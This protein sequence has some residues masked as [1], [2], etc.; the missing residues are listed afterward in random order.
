MDAATARGLLIEQF[1][2]VWAGATPL[3]YDNDTREPPPAPAS[4]ARIN[5]R[6]TGAY[7]RTLGSKYEVMAG[8]V[9]VTLYTEAGAGTDPFD[10]LATL[11]RGA[12]RRRFLGSPGDILIT[13][14]SVT[15]ERGLD[16]KGWYQTLIST[17]FEYT[18]TTT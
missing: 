15:E 10:T 18:E 1:E 8:S 5:I 17:R 7:T 9:F 12:L 3:R 6:H 4:W 14:S 11:A 16:G 2:N 13:Y